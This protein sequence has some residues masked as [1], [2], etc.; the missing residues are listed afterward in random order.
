MLILFVMGRVINFVSNDNCWRECVFDLS[1]ELSKKRKVCVFDL[2]YGMNQIIYLFSPLPRV[3]L[4]EYLVGDK[5]QKEVLNKVVKNLFVVKTSSVFFDYKKY[6]LEIKDL[7]RKIS[8]EFDYIFL[9]GVVGEYEMLDFRNLLSNEI[10]IIIDNTIESVMFA[11]NILKK[12]WRFENLKNKKIILNN[13]K[14]IKEIKGEMLS[15]DK[16]EEVLKIEVLFI[17]SK[18]PCGKGNVNKIKKLL[19]V[20]IEN[21]STIIL[22]YEKK[23]RG[24]VGFFRRRFYEK[25]E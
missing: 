19:C 4:R 15:K 18:L 7:I 3:D 14:V 25:F 9:V 6:N 8:F 5:N 16:V 1:K 22:N 11:K 13:Y 21:N 20:A 2:G 23:F 24:V 12:C 17:K 10:F